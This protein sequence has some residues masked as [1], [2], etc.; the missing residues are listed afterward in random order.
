MAANRARVAD[1]GVSQ[2]QGMLMERFDIDSG[3]AFD[4]LRRVSQAKNMR[5]HKVAAELV[6]TR[7]TPGAA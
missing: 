3:R 6:A 7:K 5:L 2:A 1:A 4:V